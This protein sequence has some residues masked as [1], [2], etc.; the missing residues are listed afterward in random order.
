[1]T[2]WTF[3]REKYERNFILC[4]TW[5]FGNRLIFAVFSEVN[6]HVKCG[7]AT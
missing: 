2:L 7:P 6:G 3:V 4:F 5:F 1:M